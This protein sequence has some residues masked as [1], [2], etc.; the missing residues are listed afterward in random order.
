LRI[1]LSCADDFAEVMVD[2][3]S[4]LPYQNIEK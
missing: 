4:D 1:G 3:L 2:K